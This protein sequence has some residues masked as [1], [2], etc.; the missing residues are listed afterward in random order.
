MNN[1]ASKVNAI[2]EALQSFDNING[3]TGTEIATKIDRLFQRTLVRS[4]NLEIELL[5]NFVQRKIA[6]TIGEPTLTLCMDDEYQ[7]QTAA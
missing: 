3:Q 5:P 4:A 7:L 6:I 2:C 1:N